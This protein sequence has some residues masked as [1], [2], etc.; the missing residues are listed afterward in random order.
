MKKYEDLKKY[1]IMCGNNFPYIENTFESLDLYGLISKI[2]KYLGAI[3]NNMEVF[4]EELDEFKK[5]I[6]NI[7]LDFTRINEELV[8]LQNEIIEVN[9]QT[10]AEIYYNLNKVNNT[11]NNKIDTAVSNLEDLI[12]NMSI[13]DVDV[14]NPINGQLE[15]IQKVINDLYD[16]KR[17]YAITAGEF[18]AL[19]LTASEYDN[20]DIMAYDFDNYSK[21]ILEN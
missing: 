3:S 5:V 8:R 1:S 14:I 12:N 20:K 21:S 4:K 18:D 16:A 19:Q 17:I 2:L 10:K 7:D 13:E 15:N 11:L 6:D 9:G